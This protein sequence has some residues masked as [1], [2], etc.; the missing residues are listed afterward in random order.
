MSKTFPNC[1]LRVAFV[2]YR[3]KKDNEEFIIE[4][5]TSNLTKVLDTVSKI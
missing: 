2:G 4:P 5:F 1:T 3:D